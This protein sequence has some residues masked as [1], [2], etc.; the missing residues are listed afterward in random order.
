[1]KREIGSL[2]LALVCGIAVGQTVYVHGTTMPGKS[3][4][5]DSSYS[6]ASQ[7]SITGTVVGIGRSK[8]NHDMPTNTRLVVQALGKKSSSYLVELGPQWF[9]SDQST[10]PKL[11]QWVKI[12]GSAI[13]DHGQKKILAKTVQ[14]HNHDVLA[15]RRSNGDPYWADMAAPTQTA[16]AQKSNP[17]IGTILASGSFNVNGVNYPGY[18]VQTSTGPQNIVMMPENSAD[19]Y[20]LPSYSLVGNIRVIGAG[21]YPVVTVGGP[22]G[23]NPF[24]LPTTGYV[25]T[26]PTGVYTFPRW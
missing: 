9:L 18:I 25:G 2:G 20:P 5:Y 21:F 4:P 14:L 11:G 7:V 10:K 23:P 26:P 19:Y 1:M 12:T 13:I 3:S 22:W 6:L 8:P 24:V 17:V 15:L 16:T